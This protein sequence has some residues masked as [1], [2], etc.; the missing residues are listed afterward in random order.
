M[1]ELL[2]VVLIIGILA[3]IALPQ[4]QVSV[5]KA[6]ASEMF[7]NVKALRTASDAYELATGQRPI[8]FDQIDIEIP[9]VSTCDD[10][11]ANYHV[12]GCIR[13]AKDIVYGFDVDGYIHSAYKGIAISSW[14]KNTGLWKGTYTCAGQV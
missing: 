4:Y 5:A 1:I 13:T 7:I 2:V 14:Y 12:G 11:G 10:G 9:Y 8:S 3:A 6:R